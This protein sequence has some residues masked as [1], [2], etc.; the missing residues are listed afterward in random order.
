MTA[1]AVTTSHTFDEIAYPAAGYSYWRTGDIRLD[2]L[3]HPPLALYIMSVPYFVLRPDLPLDSMAWKKKDH[4]LFGEI[5]LYGDSRYSA[6]FLTIAARLGVILFTLAGI[7]FASLWIDRLFGVPTGLLFLFLAVFEPNIVANGALATNDIVVAVFWFATV[8]AGM[9][10][11][12]RPRLSRAVALGGFLGAAL[13]SKHTALVLVP[14]AVLPIFFGP[15]RS[16]KE[17]FFSLLI[18]LGIPSAMI[19]LLYGRYL[20]FYFASLLGR[21]RDLAGI[22]EGKPFYLLGELS[23]TGWWYYYPVALLVKVPLATLIFAAAGAVVMAK[24]RFADFVLLALP[25]VLL[26]S[27]CMVSHKDLG[28]R[29]LLPCSLTAALLGTVFV[30]GFIRNFPRKSARAALG[31]LLLLPVLESAV[32]FPHFLSY[33]N[34][35]A[36]GPRNGSRWLLD[37][38]LDW[39]QDLPALADAWNRAS[40][41]PLLLSYFGSARPEAWGVKGLRFYPQNPAP[42]E[43]RRFPWKSNTVWWAV[44]A[45]YRPRI[46]RDIP[47]M[48]EWFSKHKPIF[49]AGYSIFVYDGSSLRYTLFSSKKTGAV[50]VAPKEI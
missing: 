47:G 4:Y 34:V 40:R 37:S 36:G 3:H 10:Y 22:S 45:T 12:R 39:G 9:E 21:T 42:E 26:I 2:I 33:F 31:L 14:T 20:P 19:A 43:W 13:L 41:P 44:S 8:L 15:K 38:N 1:Q 28:Y 23:D 11:L 49:T 25:V 6:R 16:A 32:V 7:G 50:N 24:K 27:V 17:R 48:K 30:V 18:V 29:Y 46:A 35:V 5:F